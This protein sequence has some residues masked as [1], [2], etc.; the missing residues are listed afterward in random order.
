MARLIR[1]SQIPN[2]ST[3]RF[4]A[5]RES[6][7]RLA[8]LCRFSF[9]RQ[10]VLALV[11]SIAIN[12]Y[13]ALCKIPRPNSRC[14]DGFIPT[15]VDVQDGTMGIL[16]VM[17]LKRSNRIRKCRLPTPFSYGTIN[18]AWNSVVD[19]SEATR[20]CYPAA[21]ISVRPAAL[22]SPGVAE[23]AGTRCALSPTG[24]AGGDIRTPNCHG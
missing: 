8:L 10:D 4:L 22:E 24:R 18:C 5:R 7:R 12:M 13:Q 21:A 16:L 23:I 19:A 6:Y 9:A 2:V 3:S 1:G 20:C 14:L 15:T 17:A 11:H